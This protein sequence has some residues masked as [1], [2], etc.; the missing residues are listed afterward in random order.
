MCYRESML[1]FLDGWT[2]KWD[3]WIDVKSP[4]IEPFRCRS[5]G[6]TSAKATQHLHR[7]RRNASAVMLL[8][9][10]LNRGFEFS[11]AQTALL[12]AD[13]DFDQAL[14]LLHNNDSDELD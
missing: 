2:S 9:E 4:R 8:E 7:R 1:S 12:I 10:L 6:D 5:V 11:A 14:H 3:E 13:Y